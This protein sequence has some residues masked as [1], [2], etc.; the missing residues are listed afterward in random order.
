MK[1]QPIPQPNLEIILISTS[2]ARRDGHYKYLQ[3]AQTIEVHVACKRRYTLKRSGELRYKNADLKISPPAHADK[4]SPPKSK[5][6]KL[7]DSFDYETDCFICGQA[8]SIDR[9]TKNRASTQKKISFV[10]DAGIGLTLSAILA[11]KRDNFSREALFRIRNV[12]LHNKGARYHMPCY[13]RIHNM[14]REG[15]S[16]R[17]PPGRPQSAEVTEQMHRIYDYIEHSDDLQFSLVDLKET[18]GI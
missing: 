8:A 7:S 11:D 1:G 16:S 4:V 5:L 13:M 18:L 2:R 3:S 6:R 10:K 15:E 14:Q 9:E 17:R 12:E